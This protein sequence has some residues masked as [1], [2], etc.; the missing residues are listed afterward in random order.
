MGTLRDTAAGRI[1]RRIIAGLACPSGRH[2][3][4]GDSGKLVAVLDPEV[5]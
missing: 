1:G 3:A 4:Q 5:L 2:R